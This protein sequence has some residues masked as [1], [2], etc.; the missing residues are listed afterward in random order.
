MYLMADVVDLGLEKTAS[1]CPACTAG[2]KGGGAGTGEEREATPTLGRKEGGA[3][4]G[5]DAAGEVPTPR[6]AT[7]GEAAWAPLGERRRR[8]RRRR[9]AR[10][11]EEASARDE[12]SEAAASGGFPLV[13]VVDQYP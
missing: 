11:E 6:C 7:R 5:C 2:R 10:R 12:R 4:E 3:R 13:W 8:R 9:D 1:L